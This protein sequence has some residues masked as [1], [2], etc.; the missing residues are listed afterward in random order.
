MYFV[1][2]YRVRTLDTQTALSMLHTSHLVGHLKYHFKMVLIV[3]II[4]SLQLTNYPL[5]S[6]MVIVVEQ[7]M[8]RT[9]QSRNL[10]LSTVIV[11]ALNLGMWFLG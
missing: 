1:Q 9:I 4:E 2:D 8:L 3:Q 6:L 5:I 10:L 11:V 7:M